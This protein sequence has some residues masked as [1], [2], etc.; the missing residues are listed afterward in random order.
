MNLDLNHILSKSNY[1]IHEYLVI[2]L[3]FPVIYA[4]KV[5]YGFSLVFYNE[6]IREKEGKNK[7]KND[8][9]YELPHR[10]PENVR[11]TFVSWYNGHSLTV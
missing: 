6:L 2:T 9:A 8:L 7:S 11:L 10:I 5:I 4:L 1:S 3:P